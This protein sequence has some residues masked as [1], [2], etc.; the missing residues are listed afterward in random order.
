MLRRSFTDRETSMAHIRKGEAMAR[1]GDDND[2]DEMLLLCNN[3][4]SKLSTR[5]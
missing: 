2:A 1:D 5:T 3:V 4:A